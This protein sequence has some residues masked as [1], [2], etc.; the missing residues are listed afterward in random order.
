MTHFC[1]G[2]RDITLNYVM[3]VARGLESCND[4]GKKETAGLR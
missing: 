3:I 4:G 2:M 1:R